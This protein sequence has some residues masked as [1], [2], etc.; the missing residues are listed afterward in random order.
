[1]NAIIFHKNGK[2]QKFDRVAEITYTKD[3]DCILTFENGSFRLYT[4]EM[5]VHI[6]IK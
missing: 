2:N 1:M 3:G 6:E 5:Q 4:P